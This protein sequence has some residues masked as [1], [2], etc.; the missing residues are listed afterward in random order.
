M[1]VL[2]GDLHLLEPDVAAATAAYEEAYATAEQ[3]G[4]RMSQL[5][6][7]ARL[8][9]VA[10]DAERPGRLAT[11]RT[12]HATFTEGFRTRDL[13]EAGELLGG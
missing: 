7:A 11:L 6:A 2:R 4:A 10:G 8:V 3:F 1:S 13:Q 5:R 12:V 9:R